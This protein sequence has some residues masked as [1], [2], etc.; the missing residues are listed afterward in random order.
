MDS[1]A[2]RQLAKIADGQTAAQNEQL[3]AR[4]LI[5]LD[6]RLKR[7]RAVDSWLIE[8]VEKIGAAVGCKI[9]EHPA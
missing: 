3:F 6:E 9:E 8:Q 5:D 7:Q 1:T 2:I 4:A